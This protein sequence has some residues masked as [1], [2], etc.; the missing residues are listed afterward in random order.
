M[1]C[2]NCGYEV[3]PEAARVS[4][5]GMFDSHLFERLDGQTPREVANN[6]AMYNDTRPHP[7][8]VG[9]AEVDDLGPLMLCPAAV[10]DE[11]GKDIRRVGKMVYPNRPQT[12]EAL[13][14]W[15]QALE[16][17]QDIPRLLSERKP[18][19]D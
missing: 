17:D 4:T 1:K 7:A 19:P 14:E 8:R 11:K 5:Y 18:S 9:G 15:I 6:W 10:L 16:E 13:Q 2:P 12:E 3:G